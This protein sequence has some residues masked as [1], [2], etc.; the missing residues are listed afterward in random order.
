VT[1]KNGDISAGGLPTPAADEAY[2][3]RAFKSG[4][5]NSKKEVVMLNRIIDPSPTLRAFL[6]ARRRGATAAELKV[7]RAADQATRDPRTDVVVEFKPT[8]IEHERNGVPD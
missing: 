1:E 6:D 3:G 2:A 7:L 4:R 5:H 8:Q